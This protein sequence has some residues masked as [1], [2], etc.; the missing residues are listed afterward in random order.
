VDQANLLPTERSRFSFGFY[1]GILAGGIV[2]DQVVKLFVSD[3]FRN[4]NF[5]FSLLLPQPLMYGIYGCVLFLVAAY[6]VK[7]FA[8]MGVGQKIGW[9]LVLGGALSNIGERIVL[10]YVRDFIFLLG[11]ILNVADFLILAGIAL[12]LYR[13]IFSGL[14]HSESGARE[15]GTSEK[16]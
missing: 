1:F 15:K 6:L 16:I 2:L 8:R 5:A 11:G 13:E 4:Y 9:S 12:L 7:R 14:R 3:P 10:G